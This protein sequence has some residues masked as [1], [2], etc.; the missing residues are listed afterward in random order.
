MTLHLRL[1]GKVLRSLVE[2]TTQS[3]HPRVQ[4]PSAAR[5]YNPTVLPLSNAE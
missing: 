1:K 4:H 5:R 3:G 2:V